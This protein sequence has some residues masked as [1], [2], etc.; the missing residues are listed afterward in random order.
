MV[1]D[2]DVVARAVA[3][4]HCQVAE[5]GFGLAFV[6]FFRD[7]AFD[8]ADEFKQGFVVQIRIVEIFQRNAAVFREVVPAILE[9]APDAV[10]VVAIVGFIIVLLTLGVAFLAGTLYQVALVYL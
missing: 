8:A 2:A 6:G 4:R 5:H 9:H 10:L 7:F 3:Q 1:F